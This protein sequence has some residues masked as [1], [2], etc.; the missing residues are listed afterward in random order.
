MNR[1]DMLKTV[2]AIYAAAGQGDF[3]TCE[4]MLTDDFVAW[5]ADSLPMAGAYR[6][7]GGLRELFFKVV[8]M[9]DIA[10]MDVGDTAVGQDHV[11][12]MVTIRFQ[13]P[14]LA[15]APLCEVFRFRDGKVCEIRPY[16]YDPAP[17]VAAARAKG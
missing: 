10:G 4:T 15:P 12:S 17:V 7:R 5:E 14:S 16:Y 2:Q 3:D 11:I 13:D 9:M 1:D 8:G 6:G